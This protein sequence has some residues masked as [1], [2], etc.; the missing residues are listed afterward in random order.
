MWW[1]SAWSWV[2]FVETNGSSNDFTL[3]FTLHLWC[4]VR[5]NRFV[6]K[7]NTEHLAR[8]GIWL[9]QV[10]KSHFRERMGIVSVMK[11]QGRKITTGG[12][13]LSILLLSGYCTIKRQ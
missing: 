4:F 11:T 3:H 2:A 12:F 6:F 1:K 10:L 13:K 9:I 7:C 8:T 5:R